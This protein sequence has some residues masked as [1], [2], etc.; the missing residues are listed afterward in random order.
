MHPRLYALANLLQPAPLIQVHAA[1][2]QRHRV[3]LWL[4]RD[5]LI[6]PVISGNKWRKLKYPLQHALS[7]GS[8]TIISMGGAW[9]NHLH[10]LAFI[11]QALGLKTIAMLRG[12][13][14]RYPSPTLQDIMQW[15]MHIIPLSR[16]DYQQLRNYKH[17]QAL[18]TWQ[19][20]QYWLPE[21]GATGLA[22]NGVAEILTEITIPYDYLCVAC[23]TGTTLAGLIPNNQ[24]KQQVIGFAAL[25]AG[26][27]L[28]A[29]VQNLLQNQKCPNNW[30][31]NTD[32]HFG[33][34]AKSTAELSAFIRQFRA[35]SNI[36]LDTLYTGKL[37][38]AI[39]DLL[40]QGFF[41]AGERIIA[42]HTGGLQGNRPLVRD[43]P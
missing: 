13:Y 42:I 22:L 12:E 32:Y 36:P 24:A 40:Q 43:K 33:G 31:I 25:K 34:F 41:K 26:D 11:G 6:H 21:G 23:G 14:P 2:L 17:W 38:F 8:D 15:G 20:G 10:A 9:S 19:P 28:T 30:H 3:E 16:G 5:D 27:F 35:E 39:F 4:K 37:L 7:V 29:D 1:L 18:P